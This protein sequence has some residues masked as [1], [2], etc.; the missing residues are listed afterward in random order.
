MRLYDHDHLDQPVT[1]P[2]TALRARLSLQDMGLYVQ[3][4]H[5]LP[6]RAAGPYLEQVV[7]E[8]ANSRFGDEVGEAGLRAGF[9]RLVDA[10][11]LHLSED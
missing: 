3:I 9:Q 8:L 2:A 10:G 6:A 5:L 11:L 4:R 7:T 1:V